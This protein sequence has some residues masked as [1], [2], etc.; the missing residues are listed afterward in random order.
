MT[1]N[2]YFGKVSEVP[3]INKNCNLY[4]IEVHHLQIALLSSHIRSFAL[5]LITPPAHTCIE[6]HEDFLSLTFFL[7]LLEKFVNG[8]TA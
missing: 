3:Q 8:K 5:N 2:L 6:V 7:R 4:G 1:L